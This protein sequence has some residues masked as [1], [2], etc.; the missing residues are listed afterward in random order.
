MSEYRPKGRWYIDANITRFAFPINFS[1]RKSKERTEYV[2]GFLFFAI[3]RVKD[4][5]LTN[6]GEDPMDITQG[7]T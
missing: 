6:K 1:Y 4:Y 3:G 7:T 2:I 5:R